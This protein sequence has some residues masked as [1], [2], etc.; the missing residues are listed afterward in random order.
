M[1][2]VHW[3][4]LLI[5]LLM[6]FFI[7]KGMVEKIS[8]QTKG[9]GKLE[10]VFRHPPP[11]ESQS[12]IGEAHRYY[13]LGLAAYRAGNYKAAVENFTETLRLDSDAAEAYHG[14]ALAWG[15][16]R[17][18]NAASQDFVTAAALYKKQNRKEEIAV[19]LKDIETLKDSVPAN[20]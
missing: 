1:K 6:V 20:R 17:Q 12:R 19:V 2:P 14:R 3:L 16:M 4:V 10:A 11:S 9:G 5:V 18:E 8:W 15:N 7:G 13:D